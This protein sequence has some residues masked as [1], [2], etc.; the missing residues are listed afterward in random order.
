MTRKDLVPGVD[1][2]KRG[3]YTETGPRGGQYGDKKMKKSVTTGWYVGI[4]VF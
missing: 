2:P 4:F 1:A 3:V